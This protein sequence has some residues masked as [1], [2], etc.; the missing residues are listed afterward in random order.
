MRPSALMTAPEDPAGRNGDETRPP[1]APRNGDANVFALCSC[2]GDAVVR[3]LT[4]M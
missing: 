4:C 2:A 3:C 1:F